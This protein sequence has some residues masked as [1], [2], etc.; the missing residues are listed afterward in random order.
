MRRI[1]WPAIALAVALLAGVP[2]AFAQFMRDHEAEGGLRSFHGARSV[3]KITRSFQS[4]AEARTELERILSAVGLGYVA[5]RIS[6]RATAQ[7]PNAEAFIGKDGER[8]IFYNPSFMQRVKQKTAEHWSLVSILAHEVGHHV[9][10]HTVIEGHDHK[11][12]LEA[13]YFSGFVLRRLGATLDQADAAMRLISPKMP[14]PSHP[15][16]DDRLT[17]ITIG[18]TDGGASGAPPGFKDAKQADSGAQTAAAEA[19][20]ICREVEGMS[21]PSMLSVLGNQHKGTPAGD[22]IAARLDELQQAESGKQAAEA[23]RKKAAEDAKAD[24]ERQRLAN[25]K[26]EDERKRAEEA[27]RQRQAVLRAAEDRRQGVEARAYLESGTS[28]L[29]KNNY[30][31]AIAD[32]STAIE[33]DPQGNAYRLRGAAHREKKNYDRAIADLTQAIEINP[34]DGE[35]YRGR[36]VT[37]AE[38]K[39]YD[40]AIADLTKAIEINRND[41]DAY[42]WRSIAF[43]WK[44]NYDRSIADLTKAIEIYRQDSEADLELGE[45]YGAR[46][47]TFAEM[48]NYDRAIADLTKAIEA[49]SQDGGAYRVRGFANEMRGRTTEAIKDYRRALKIDPNDRTSRAALGRLGASP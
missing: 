44:K 3:G 16:L 14:G 26:S 48:K 41:G 13:D 43:S 12:E 19:V 29:S 6:L 22:C 7:T 17:A 30:D 20:R 40:G 33:L 28:S 36:G 5:D 37:F 25:L 49:N 21:S 23:E 11:F 45:A 32:L 10:F 46:G 39:N 24:A 9:A 31:R 8:F 15:G 2:P 18:W 1:G 42:Q 38:M 34:K 47:A 4:D 35:A 27:E